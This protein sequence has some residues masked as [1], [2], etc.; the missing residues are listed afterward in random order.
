IGRTD[1]VKHQI[2][3]GSAK[4]IKQ[5]P[6]RLPL[7]KRDVAC[8]AVDKM[9]KDGVIEP[10]TSPW[11]SPVVLVAKKNGNLRFCVDYRKLNDATIKDSY[12]LPRIDDTL[13]ALGGSQWFSTLDLKSGYWQVA[14]DPADKEKTAF[15]IGGGLWHFRVMPFGLCNAPA[16]FE[17]LMDHVLAGLPWN[18]CLVYLDDIIVHGRTFSEQ[19]ENLRKVFACLRKANLKLSPE[20]CNLF[21]REVK[22][23]GHIISFEI[24]KRGNHRTDIL[25]S[26][27]TTESL[28]RKVC[29][30][31]YLLVVMD[32]FSK[33]PE[34]YALQNQ[35][36]KTV[37]TVIVNEFVCRFGV[38]LELHSDQGT[39]FESA[40]FQEMCSLLVYER[41]DPEVVESYSTYVRELQENLQVTHDFARKYIDQ[42]FESMRK[43]Y[44]VDSSAC[45]FNE[46]DQV[47]L[48]NPRKKKGRSVKLMRP[49]EGPKLAKMNQHEK[50]QRSTY[51]TW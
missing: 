36:A 14:M 42:S 34:A 38:P 47:W 13:D 29:R 2:I 24:C 39:N 30:N 9:L 5:P 12:P 22:Y 7:A 4:P 41:P 40:V 15:S 48:Y 37:A 10:S 27:D 45:I 21:R 8:Q 32:Y 11:S 50:E 33:W 18:I 49:W 1:I 3:T 25:E 28:S 6:R 16:T 23:L 26:S 46:G 43:R 51:Q 17:R 20:K 44:D 31:R 35:E 19:L